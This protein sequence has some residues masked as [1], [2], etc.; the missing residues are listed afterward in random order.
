MGF[1]SPPDPPEPTPPPRLDRPTDNPEEATRRRL[2]M[3]ARRQGRSDFMV[4]LMIPEGP[5]TGQ[6]LYIPGGNNA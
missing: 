4:D 6:G 5:N 1:L 2:Q 3:D